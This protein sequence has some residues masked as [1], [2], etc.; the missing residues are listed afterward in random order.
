MIEVETVSGVRTSFV[1][2]DVIWLVGL[3]LRVLRNCGSIPA[4]VAS[5]TRR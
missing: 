2:G 4:V 1:A 5:I 3:D